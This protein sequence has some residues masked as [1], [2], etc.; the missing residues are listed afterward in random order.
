[1]NRI[2]SLCFKSI[3]LSALVVPQL[4][5]AIDIDGFP[6]ICSEANDRQA[7]PG[8]ILRLGMINASEEGLFFSFPE[9]NDPQNLQNV[10][11]ADNVGLIGQNPSDDFS[12]Q[13]KVGTPPSTFV[14]AQV[15]VADE[16]S[17]P[18]VTCISRPIPI[19][20][21]DPSYYGAEWNWLRPTIFFQRLRWKRF[22]PWRWR[23]WYGDSFRR[24][25]SSWRLRDRSR[26]ERRVRDRDNDGIPDRLD[27]DRD[28]DGI[29]DSRERRLRRDRTT[30][31]ARGRQ[32][33]LGR[34]SDNDGI[35]DRL[36]NF[37]NL[38]RDRDNDGTPDRLER[39]TRRATT[40]TSDTVKKSMQDRL[41]R[42][43]QLRATRDI[44]KVV[45]DTSPA[46]TVRKLRDKD[47]DDD[48]IKENRFRRN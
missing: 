44:K 21:Y 45:R 19:R 20:S 43:K 9:Q 5:N 23:T 22:R 11:I 30:D 10:G 40:D 34:D 48:E 3:I 28:G 18:V 14:V 7:L 8:H 17:E 36:E 25:R 29:R 39:R 16:N 2:K 26:L 24:I 15:F 13:I 12:E 32:G 47:D 38:R 6:A 41:E 31:G 4:A 42:M 37:K 1:M 46:K 33:R 35:P 27:R